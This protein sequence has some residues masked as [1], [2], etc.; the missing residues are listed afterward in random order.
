M[1]NIP[2][3]LSLLLQMAQASERRTGCSRRDVTSC[4][5]G[6]FALSARGAPEDCDPRPRRHG[7]SAALLCT[8]TLIALVTSNADLALYRVLDAMQ[9]LHR[10]R[11][12]LDTALLYL[13]PRWLGKG[14]VGR[15]FEDAVATIDALADRFCF[16]AVTARYSAAADATVDWLAANGLADMPVIHSD[17][18]HPGDDS[19][20]A[21]KRDAILALRS[22]HGLDPVIGVGDRP[23]DLRAYVQAGLHACIVVH[24]PGA[25]AL[26]QGG[27]GSA[28]APRRDSGT[29]RDARVA[30]Q[31]VRSLALQ[32]SGAVAPLAP[33][34]VAT[35]F[36]D[37]GMARLRLHAALAST[38]MQH[39]AALWGPPV[40]SAADAVAGGRV[41][42]AMTPRPA[43]RADEPLPP[44]WAQVRTFLEQQAVVYG[45]GASAAPGRGGSVCGR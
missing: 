12:G 16:V 36:T 37:S 24:G 1:T 19:R 11:G 10:A 32:M 33:L 39:A 3:R 6:C 30:E 45:D 2:R 44:V 20:I 34:P 42:E 18:P 14:V 29:P 8:A 9:V 15:P 5:N 40:V 26:E 38:R 23:S 17:R 41:G 35:F 13:L 4:V 7:E 27:G 31:L 22:Q 25:R 43:L 28:A 21:F